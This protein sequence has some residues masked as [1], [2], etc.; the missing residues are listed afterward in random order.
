MSWRLPIPVAV[1]PPPMSSVANVFCTCIS[2]PLPSHES[3]SPI[4]QGLRTCS[5]PLPASALAVVND[6]G[7]SAR[8]KVMSATQ[9]SLWCPEASGGLRLV[10]ATTWRPSPLRLVTLVPSP[11][12]PLFSYR[13]V[14]VSGRI[15]DCGGVAKRGADDL[16]E[17]LPEHPG[18]LT[19]A[20][21]VYSTSKNACFRLSHA[22]GSP[23][24][25][26][27]PCRPC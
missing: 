18:P 1:P 6:R 13:A 5:N 23:R 21:L 7:L 15:T 8:Q 20:A 2:G 19:I 4:A 16:R 22:R 11:R 14:W 10:L 17:P 26:R 25:H 3:P 12:Y 9:P 27:S 24:Q